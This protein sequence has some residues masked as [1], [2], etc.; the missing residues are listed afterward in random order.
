MRRSLACSFMIG[1]APRG[2]IASWPCRSL[3]LSLL[4]MLQFRMKLQRN[5][6]DLVPRQNA[7]SLSMI[8]RYP[9]VVLAAFTFILFVSFYSYQYEPFKPQIRPPMPT[10]SSGPFKGTW[11]TTRDA[12]NLLMTDA[13]C[14]HAFPNLFKE[15]ERA[16]EFRSGNPITLKE[17][18]S[19]VP[20]RGYNRAMIY[21]NQ[22]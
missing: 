13:Q 1:W 9:Y 3:F 11:N 21:D 20:I 17:L 14:S 7:F 18:D 8:R 4:S 5:A 12:R 19:I 2:C 16:V 15:I 10:F 6:W 22:V